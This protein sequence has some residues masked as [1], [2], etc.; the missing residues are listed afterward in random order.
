[1]RC[2]IAL[3]LILVGATPFFAQDCCD[4]IETD[5]GKTV[6]DLNLWE[7]NETLVILG[8]IKE[9]G[10]VFPSPRP[11]EMRVK[12][13]SV[14]SG[15][16]DQKFLKRAIGDKSLRN[17]TRSYPYCRGCNARILLVV[18]KNGFYLP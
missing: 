7:P 8:E 1:M 12:V 16:W 4:R 15:R 9:I 17:I 3:V 6:A 18:T 13:L 11:T 2:F 10:K 5:F 14:I